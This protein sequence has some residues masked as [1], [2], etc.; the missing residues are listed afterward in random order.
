MPD[1]QP[2]ELEVPDGVHG[3]EMAVEVLRAWIA[4]GALHVVFEPDSFAHDTS[5]WGR[6]LSEIAH[7]VARASA[8]QGQIGEADAIK[9]IREAF[10]HGIG[11]LTA[12]RLG[13][14]KG[15]TRH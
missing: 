2:M 12:D 14:I 7:H 10:D 15:R 11:H 4:D 5:E 1:D 13:R 6:L 3:A 8:V 9:A